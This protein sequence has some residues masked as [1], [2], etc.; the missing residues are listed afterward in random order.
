MQAV[1]L[2]FTLEAGFPFHEWIWAT[3]NTQYCPT[4][5]QLHPCRHLATVHQRYK[6]LAWSA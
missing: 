4:T 1:L 2:K 5:N 3:T 6:A